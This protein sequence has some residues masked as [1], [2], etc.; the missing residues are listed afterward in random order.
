MVGVKIRIERT[1]QMDS[2]LCNALMQI[3]ADHY[4]K[5]CIGV[6]M[7]DNR[8]DHGTPPESIVIAF[9]STQNNDD[10]RPLSIKEAVFRYS[11]QGVQPVSLDTIPDYTENGIYYKEAYAE[12]IYQEN[13]IA[14][15]MIQF[16]KRFARCY[17]YNIVKYQ[18][19]I[20][21]T[22]EK[23]IWIS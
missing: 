12:L 13:G 17:R 19:N 7:N 23:L 21:I 2:T 22:N 8:N 3:C 18:N 10:W 6:K 16:G 4:Q 11:S 9:G 20:Q 14:Y 1:I 15:I 5:V